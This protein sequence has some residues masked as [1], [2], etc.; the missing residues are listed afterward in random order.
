MLIFNAD[1][2]QFK[3]KME[4]K[5]QQVN[6]KRDQDVIVENS[7]SPPTTL[8]II[9]LQ[10]LQEEGYEKL[11]EDKTQGS[12]SHLS[13]WGHVA[14]SHCVFQE[15]NSAQLWPILWTNQKNWHLSDT[16]SMMC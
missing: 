7:F 6:S 8:M 13:G 14:D 9:F 4:T 11:S 10:P 15:V 1:S 12:S 2:L 5:K 3:Y 16:P